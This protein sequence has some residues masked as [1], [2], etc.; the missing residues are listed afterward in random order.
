M[1]SGISPVPREARPY[2]GERAG[3]VTRLIAATVDA[4]S[5]AAALVAT[6]AGVNVAM[7]LVNPRGF[8]FAA[9]SIL[10]SVTTALV[11]CVVYLAAAW[12]ITGRTYGDHVMGL[13]VV[14]GRGSRVRA[15]RALVRAVFCVGFPV[16]LLWC[17]VSRTRR[18]LQDAVLGT[19]VI[20]DWR[21]RNHG[22]ET[23][24]PVIHTG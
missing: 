10:A 17:A 22:G 3:L 23:L 7:F 8:E 1:E 14:N 13:R 20:Y 12:S 2:Q 6:Y 19:S 18:S 5:V 15:P 16:G 9:A 24:E 21:P 4:L 11:V